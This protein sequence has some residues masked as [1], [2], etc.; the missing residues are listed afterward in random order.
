MNKTTPK[1]TEALDAVRK[2]AKQY[3]K[4]FPRE[5]KLTVDRHDTNIIFGILSEESSKKEKEG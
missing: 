5:I 4:V 1:Q 2:A 3:F